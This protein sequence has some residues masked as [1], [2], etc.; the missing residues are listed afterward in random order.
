MF[1]YV[2]VGTPGEIS[3]ACGMSWHVII[4][5]LEAELALDPLFNELPNLEI[6]HFI[7]HSMGFYKPLN[8]LKF[9]KCGLFLSS[10]ALHH[11]N[12]LW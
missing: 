12:L 2:S 5:L 1:S 10:T 3:Q 9:L 11:S 6:S 8:G 7:F 4:N